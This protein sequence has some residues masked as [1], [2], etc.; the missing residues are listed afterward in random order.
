MENGLEEDEQQQTNKSFKTA[1]GK[2]KSSDMVKLMLKC[3]LDLT[4]PCQLGG[5]HLGRLCLDSYLRNKCQ[6]D[7][8]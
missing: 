3:L 1:Q 6:V 8:F 2:L 7:G 5:C 4:G